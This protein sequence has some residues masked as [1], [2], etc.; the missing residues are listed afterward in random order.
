MKKAAYGCV[1][2]GMHSVSANT[3]TASLLCL[4]AGMLILSRAAVKIVSAHFLHALACCA[5]LTFNGLG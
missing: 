3:I 1:T 5:H 4:L 2:C